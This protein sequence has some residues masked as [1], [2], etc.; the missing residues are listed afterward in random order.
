MFIQFDPGHKH[1]YLVEAVDKVKQTLTS[2]EII[3]LLSGKYGV[4][5]YLVRKAINHLN[6]N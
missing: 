6:G 4:K 5:K 2:G 1:A 3:N